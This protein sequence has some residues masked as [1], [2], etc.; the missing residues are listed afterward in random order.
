M[1]TNNEQSNLEGEVID[2]SDA[3]EAETV[4]APVAPTVKSEPKSVLTDEDKRDLNL[5]VRTIDTSVLS[6]IMY[7]QS[8]LVATDFFNSGALPKHLQNPTQAFVTIVTGAEMGLKPMEAIQ[9]LYIINGMIN[10]WGKAVPRQ[11]KKHGFKF[12]FTEENM[13]HCNVTVWRG[14]SFEGPEPGDEQ[15]TE[16]FNF[17]DADQS[18]YTKDSTG[19]LKVGWKPGQNRKMKMR[20]NVLSALIKTYI[21]DVLGQ[22]ADIQEVAADY[23]EGEVAS[24]DPKATARAGIRAALQD[25]K[26]NGVVAKSAPQAIEQEQGEDENI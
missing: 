20:Y 5:A 18:G 23:I 16:V 21:P 24:D 19:R 26:A 15:Y 9:G 7:E 14:D 12:K 3:T 22:C 11:L 17:Q 13:D 1:A 4:P 25:R 10:L 6:P 8:K 2:H